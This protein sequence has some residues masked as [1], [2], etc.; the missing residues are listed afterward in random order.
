MPPIT[1][2]ALI[3]LVVAAGA[4]AGG[5]FARFAS[6]SVESKALAAQGP[7][8]GPTTTGVTVQSPV[9]SLPSTTA[10]S[11]TSTA[12]SSPDVAT[13]TTL[14]APQPAAVLIIDRS[15]W[16]AKAPVGEY[17]TH[18]LERMTVHHTASSR[19]DVPGAPARMRGYQAFHQN[20]RGWVDVAYHFIIDRDG[21]VYEGRPVDAKGDTATGYDPTGHFL[22]C[23]DGNYDGEEPTV[24]QLKSLVGLLAWATVT[25]GL[26]PAEIAGH[27]DWAQTSCP[28]DEVYSRLKQIRTAVEAVV[29]GGGG[30][31]GYL[32]GEDAR[33]RVARI[34]AG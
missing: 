3:G 28:G 19:S 23:L 2:R 18:H 32:R 12:T 5:L 29:A 21:N 14:P 17:T 11:P 9:T 26:D 34:E 33:D 22:P 31:I 16:G 1:R 24:A 8:A 13:T 4:A 25:F 30:A 6:R 27:R 10:T 15:G 7:P 20:D